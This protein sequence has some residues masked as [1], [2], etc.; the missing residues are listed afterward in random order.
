MALSLEQVKS[1]V[2]RSFLGKGGI[3]GVGVSRAEGAIRLYVTRGVGEEPD[4]LEQVREAA[5][6]YPVLVITED[7]PEVS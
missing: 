6:P 4:L 7:R 1:Q 5:R 3:H 2:R